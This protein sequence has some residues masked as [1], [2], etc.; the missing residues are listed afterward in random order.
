MI[1]G[2]ERS[3]SFDLGTL[4]IVARC[5]VVSVKRFIKSY[6]C[7]FKQGRLLTKQGRSLTSLVSLAQ[8]MTFGVFVSLAQAMTFGVLTNVRFS[9]D[10]IG[11]VV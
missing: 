7:S 11:G 6:H 1:Q 10:N 2:F 3:F 8:A 5:V 9:D 4:R